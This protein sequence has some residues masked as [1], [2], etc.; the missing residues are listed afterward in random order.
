MT[1]T[2]A[3]SKATEAKAETPDLEEILPSE[4]EL[5]IEGM[6]VVVKRLKS[7]EFFALLK[8]ITNGLGQNISQFSLSMDDEEEMKSTVVA[9]AVLAIPNALEEFVDFMREIVA[10]KHVIDQHK[11]YAALENPEIEDSINVITVIIAQ[12]AGDFVSL[13]GKAKAAFARIPSVSRP[14]GK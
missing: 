14:T 8:I 13:V 3:A 7:R 1:V 11:V 10:A 9:M 4:E 2:K 12:E 5:T 6:P